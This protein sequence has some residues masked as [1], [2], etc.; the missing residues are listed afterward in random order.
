MNNI[1][2]TYGNLGNSRLE[3][4]KLR[5]EL[6]AQNKIKYAS[7]FMPAGFLSDGEKI[8]FGLGSFLRN[9]GYLLT[10]RRIIKKEGW[11]RKRYTECPLD[12]IEDV[13]IEYPS[14]N[15]NFGNVLFIIRD[16]GVV[17]EMI[18]KDI[19]N[20]ESVYKLATSVIRPD[21]KKE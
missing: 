8:L 21:S 17:K 3:Q 10:N 9:S 4:R 12:K 16:D 2:D 6:A 1:P 18:W 19:K 11:I 15:R 13:K 14:W 5:R 7:R 20:P